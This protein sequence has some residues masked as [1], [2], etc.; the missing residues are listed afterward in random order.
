MGRF[1]VEALAISSLNHP[2]ICTLYDVGPNYLVTELVDGET[3]RNWMKQAPPEKRRID[4]ARQVLEA[5]RAA[6]EAGIITSRL[7]AGEH[8][9]PSRRL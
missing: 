4:I 3:L 6:H 7:E 1:A 2:N 8:H 5:L 9:G